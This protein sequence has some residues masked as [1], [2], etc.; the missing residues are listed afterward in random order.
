M[1]IFENDSREAHQLSSKYLNAYRVNW[2]K[3]ELNSKKKKID[4]CFDKKK[5]FH[6]NVNE[7]K[8]EKRKEII[9]N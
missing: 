4:W 5:K 1:Y 2:R 8:K 7:R 9:E 6:I 3:T